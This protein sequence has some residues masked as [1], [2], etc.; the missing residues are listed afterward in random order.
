ML[1]TLME[2]IFLEKKSYEETT[3]CKFL[4]SLSVYPDKSSWGLPDDVQDSL[5]CILLLHSLGLGNPL[6][7]SDLDTI[8]RVIH[9][10]SEFGR[11]QVC[12]GRSVGQKLVAFGVLAVQTKQKMATLK[13][14]LWS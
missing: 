13:A 5:G 4:E 11:F 12:I 2:K 7:D 9:S 8:D 10:P 14:W 1:V 3:A 6:G